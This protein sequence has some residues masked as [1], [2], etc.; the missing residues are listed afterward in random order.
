MTSENFISYNILIIV[1]YQHVFIYNTQNHSV[2]AKELYI[3][4]KNID[5]LLVLFHDPK[6]SSEKVLSALEAIDD[7]CDNLGVSFV[8]VNYFLDWH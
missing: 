6:K 4:L 8:Q 3:M 7:E 2:S 1:K 5:H